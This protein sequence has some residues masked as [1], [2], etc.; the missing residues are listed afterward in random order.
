MCVVLPRCPFLALSGARNA[1][2]YGHGIAT[3]RIAVSIYWELPAYIVNCR[4]RVG[5]NIFLRSCTLYVSIHVATDRQL[6]SYPAVLSDG[7]LTLLFHIVLNAGS[8]VS[9]FYHG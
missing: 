8:A 4:R 7:S 1:Y 6:A 3:S 9:Q 5:T 2:N